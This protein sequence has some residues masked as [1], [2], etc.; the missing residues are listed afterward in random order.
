M[1]IMA[2]TTETI[3]EEKLETIINRMGT[4]TRLKDF[5]DLYLFNH[6]NKKEINFGILQHAIKATAKNRSTEDQL[7]T[8]I[9]KILRLKV[10]VDLLKRWNIYQATN[11]YAEGI[12]FSGTC[13]QQL[14]L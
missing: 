14:I 2:Y 3:I 5:Y 6:R 9:T 7:D 13:D 10:N 12:A 4:N 1:Q 11:K 8:Y